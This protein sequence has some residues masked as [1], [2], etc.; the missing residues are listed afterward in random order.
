MK[1]YLEKREI[2]SR[3]SIQHLEAMHRL[4][5]SQQIQSSAN[6]KY[7]LEQRDVDQLILYK[8]EMLSK[9]REVLKLSKS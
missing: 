9:K 6:D 7:N 4:Q 3:D 8:K 1:N 2:H 5:L